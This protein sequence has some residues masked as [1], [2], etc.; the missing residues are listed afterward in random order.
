MAFHGITGVRLLGLSD[1]NHPD[2]VTVGGK[3]VDGAVFTSTYFGE[4]GHPVLSS[5]AKN[6]REIFGREA[7]PFAAEAFDVTEESCREETLRGSN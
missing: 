6:Y 2:L 3:Y 5:F 1:W 4:S 7:G